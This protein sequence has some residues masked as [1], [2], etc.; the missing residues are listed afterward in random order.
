LAENLYVSPDSQ[1]SI[2]ANIEFHFNVACNAAADIQ[3]RILTR[4]PGNI[5]PT[6][7]AFRKHWSVIFLTVAD[8]KELDTSVVDEARKYLEAPFMKH[9]KEMLSGIKIFEKFKGELFKKNLL[10]RG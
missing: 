4:A 10:V 7:Q 1:T 2:K 6:Y 8:K 3:M 5:F 9:D